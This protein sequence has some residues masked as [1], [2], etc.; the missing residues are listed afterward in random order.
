VGGHS[1]WASAPAKPLILFALR[2]GAQFLIYATPVRARRQTDRT[3]GAPPMSSPLSSGPIPQRGRSTP[4]YDRLGVLGWH[5]AKPEIIADRIERLYPNKLQSTA[6]SSVFAL[7]FAYNDG[8]PFGRHV[9]SHC[10]SFGHSI[11]KRSLYL[12]RVT[13]VHVN[14]NYR[15]CT[16]RQSRH[17]TL[18]A[19]WPGCTGS[20]TYRPSI[21]ISRHFSLCLIAPDVA[22]VPTFASEYLQLRTVT[23]EPVSTTKGK[24]VREAA[25]A[26]GGIVS[27]SPTSP[28]RPI[29]WSWPVAVATAEATIAS[30]N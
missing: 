16:L 27:P 8:H 11:G 4:H 28:L 3:D 22:F 21:R 7:N 5:S 1:H 17:W 30:P 26:K 2:S 19:L 14:G 15:H 12:Y 23:V 10:D 13:Y 6:D 29:G 20:E 18:W 9:E 25:A 24:Q